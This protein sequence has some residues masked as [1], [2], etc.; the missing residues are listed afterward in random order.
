METTDYVLNVPL[1]HGGET[2]SVLTLRRPTTKEA[3]KIGFPSSFGAD[4]EKIDVNF[5]RTLQYVSKC[6]GIP[7]SVAEKI[8]LSDLLPLGMVITS[9]FGKP[10]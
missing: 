1:Q 8:D 7:P 3:M 6:A 4:G 2:I 5:E 10:E 9:F